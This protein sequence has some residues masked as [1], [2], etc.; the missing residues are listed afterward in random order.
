MYL[1]VLLPQLSFFFPFCEQ[2]PVLLHATL[3]LRCIWKKRKTIFE[4]IITTTDKVLAPS[5]GTG[6][7]EFLEIE[8]SP[9]IFSIFLTMQ[10]QVTSKGAT[11]RSL[12][13]FPAMASSNITGCM[14]HIMLIKMS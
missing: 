14:R 10:G 3:I 2:F 12:S 6:Q 5:S 4:K 11:C 7:F 13:R 1:H 8:V 9:S